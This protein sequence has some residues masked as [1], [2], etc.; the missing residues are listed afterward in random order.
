MW[1]GRLAD[2]WEGPLEKCFQQKQVSCKLWKGKKSAKTAL[3][4]GEGEHK[5]QFKYQGDSEAIVSFSQCLFKDSEYLDSFSF[6]VRNQRI[7]LEMF[8]LSDIC[9]T[10]THFTTELKQQENRENFISNVTNISV[11]RLRNRHHHHHLSLLTLHQ[12]LSLI[13]TV[14]KFAHL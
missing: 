11:K 9:P 10:L 13:P 6:P 8:P 12:N 14:L 5:E 1:R 7:F 3:K 2:S 4:Q